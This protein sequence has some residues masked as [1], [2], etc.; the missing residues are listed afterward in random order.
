MDVVQAIRLFFESHGVEPGHLLAAVSGGPDSTALLLALAAL[1]DE[2]FIVTAAHVNHHLRG[3][4]SDADEAFVRALCLEQKIRLEIA[5]GALDPAAIRELG[6]EAAA[7]EVRYRELK[8]IRERTG[9]RYILTAH[10]RDDQAETVLMRIITGSGIERLAGIAPTTADH[11]LRP[12]LDV[13]RAELGRY[14]VD[15]G[16]EAR[17]DHTNTE[18]R[19]LRNRL[20]ND[21][22]PLLSQYNP[23]V[24][25]TLARLA[26]QVRE[27]SQ[28][29]EHL[30]S[31]LS[32]NWVIRTP[33]AS[34]FILQDLPADSW[35]RRAI[36]WREIRRLAPR[37]RNLSSSDLTRLADSLH[38]LKRVSVTKGLELVR[39]GPTVMLRV[40]EPAAKPYSRALKPGKPVQLN[41]AVFHLERSGVAAPPYTDSSRSF[42]LFQLPADA[43]AETFQLRTRR[44]G[45]RFQPLGLQREKRLNEFLIDR[46]IPREQRDHLPLLTWKDEIVW[47]A[48]VEVSE[49]FKVAEP[50][51]DAYRVSMERDGPHAKIHR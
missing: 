42:Q 13:P 14:L 37:T 7:R 1:R 35:L 11:I 20:R 41:G 2:G 15:R 27:R 8:K 10:H 6:V 49:K 36:L 4:A 18:S 47:I 9:A 5:D 38:D 48:G 16:I 30:F 40:I 39:R 23:R 19:F 12:L 32:A 44:R 46:K 3:E 21:L 50:W 34:E 45:E 51:R 31:K 33:K 22:M 28:A 24:S 25:E 29:V 17:L 43:S 26:R